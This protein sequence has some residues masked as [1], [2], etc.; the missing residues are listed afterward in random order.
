MAQNCCQS[1]GKKD[2]KTNKSV[3]HEEMKQ[4]FAIQGS[5]HGQGLGTSPRYIQ[6]INESKINKFHFI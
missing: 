5:Q 3:N 1:R 4:K 6:S 2:S